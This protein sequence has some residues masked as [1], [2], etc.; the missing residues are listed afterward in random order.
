MDNYIIRV[1]DVE[2]IVIIIVGD[3]FVDV[4]VGVVVFIG[5]FVVFVGYMEGGIFSVGGDVVVID[6]IDLSVFGVL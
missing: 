4:Y 6:E 2:D 1:R 3:D 5:V